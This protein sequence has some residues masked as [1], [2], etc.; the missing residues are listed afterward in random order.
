M[1]K[2]DVVVVLDGGKVPYMLRPRTGSQYAFLGECYV[3]AVRNG[4]A[5][6]MAEKRGVGRQMFSLV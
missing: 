5:Y 2:G 1:Q 4:E 3:Y 6:D